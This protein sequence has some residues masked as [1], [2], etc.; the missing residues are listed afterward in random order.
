MTDHLG[1]LLLG[2]GT[3]GV[4]AAL[5]LG[6][7][8]THRASNVVNFAHGAIG[9]YVAFVYFE[10]RASGDFV[11]PLTIPGVPDRLHLLDRPTVG[12]SM[13]VA[14]VVAA[15]VGALSYLLIFRPL[16]T[17]PALARVVASLGL[18]T[19]LIGVM[20]VRFSTAASR[21]TMQ[22]PLPTDTFDIFGTRTQV[23]R[24][25]VAAVAIVAAVIW[26]AVSRFTNFGLATRATAENDTGATLVGISPTR[27]GVLNW[28]AA[29]MLA[30]LILILAP[31][32][33]LS[34]T[35]TPLLVVP[36]LG[37]ALLGQ[38][39]S[40]G[41]A[42]A[43]GLGI[44]MLQ[45]ELVNARADWSW[46]P[47]GLSQGT[48]FIVVLIALVWRGDRIPGRNDLTA[49]VGLPPAPDPRSTLRI[50]TILTVVA[51]IG[52]YHVDR[53]WRSALY[54]SAI[55]AIL[56]LSVVVLTGFV[57]QISLATYA[58]S[59]VAAFFMV[60]VTDSWGLGFPWSAIAGIVLAV[61]VGTIAGLP[62]TRVR[63]LA[64]AIATLAAA[65]AVEEFVFK[66]DRFT[67]GI[68]GSAVE[69]AR[70]PLPW[71]D[72]DGWAQVDFDVFALGND[73]PRRT[74]GVLVL[75]VM[76]LAVVIVVNLRRSATGRQWL[77]IRANERA[78]EAVG[79]SAARVKL[80]AN[81]VAALLAGMG[82][83]L[84]AFFFQGVS[85][86]SFTALS[87]LVVVAMTYL[88]GIAAPLGALLAGALA[89][90]GLFTQVMDTISEGSSEY[91]FAINGLALIIAAIKFPAGI[92]GGRAT[93]TTTPVEDAPV[94]ETAVSA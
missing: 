79:I 22:T 43:T 90:G 42:V 11:H 70:L 66:W 58:L 8:I 46:L 84:L 61:I 76:L 15:L 52:M 12:T 51:M 18:M 88:A 81:A 65:T 35:T 41:I 89:Q 68:G 16:R 1:Y 71:R 24:L 39:R 74:F 23:D 85:A 5:A 54:I 20:Q 69:P 28:A 45:A 6:I 38:F 30:G 83:V 62:A 91:Q 9:T 36:A 34:P 73:P 47:D 92:L 40:I 75:L 64:L 37:A 60:R 29:A 26:A 50:A 78:A 53:D 2:V 31:M 94:D 33:G 59:G 77:A 19:Y 14:M 57:G 4:F 80:S 72:D 21:I 48:P 7:V 67:G 27:L 10:F 82:G 87:S 44:G 86:S 25:W 56:A 63:G 3:G 49:S 55:S 93:R 13:V 32:G 17:A